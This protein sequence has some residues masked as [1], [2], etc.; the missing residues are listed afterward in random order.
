M[1]PLYPS[2]ISS[3]TVYLPET[4]QIT[5]LMTVREPLASKLTE[6]QV[7][8]LESIFT[9]R[10][11]IIADIDEV[12]NSRDIVNNHESKPFTENGFIRT[13]RSKE[14]TALLDAQLILEQ[15]NTILIL[16]AVS[17]VTLITLIGSLYLRK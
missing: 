16:G 14:D 7:P 8:S 9:K 2:N 10:T 4:A 12:T 1:K 11:Q 3:S 17:T 13:I 5:G 15:Q 6:T